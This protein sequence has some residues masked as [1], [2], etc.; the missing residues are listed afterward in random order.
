MKKLMLFSLSLLFANSLVLPKDID[1]QLL[2][3]VEEGD[4]EQ[5]EQLLDNGAD[6][7]IINELSKTQFVWATEDVQKKIIQMLLDHGAD[8]NIADEFGKTP[9]NQAVEE[10]NTDIIQMLL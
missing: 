3:A 4:V 6:P 1:Q 9:L 8:P 5:V 7:N 10:G 2:K